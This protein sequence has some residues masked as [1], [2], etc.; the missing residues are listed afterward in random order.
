MDWPHLE[1]PPIVEALIDIQVEAEPDL[2]ALRGLHAGLK[3]DYPHLL[4]GRQEHVTVRRDGAATQF[5]HLQRQRGFAVASANHERLVQF[6]DDGFTFNWLGP[7]ESWVSLRD[8][9]RRTFAVYFDVIGPQ[10]IS[11]IGVRYVNRIEIP[12]GVEL[13][14]VTKLH[15]QVPPGL[16]QSVGGE[17]LRVLLKFEPRTIALVSSLVEAQPDPSG[18]ACVLD[19]DVFQ[20]KPLPL[21]LEGVWERLEELREVKNKVFFRTLAADT[22]ERYR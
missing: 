18:F 22:L 19:I 6:R 16:P 8:E 1:T 10:A 14:T 20:Q 3:T 13:S 21:D 11:R 5:D 17:M 12:E 9:A 2:D 4:E 15:A 7:Y